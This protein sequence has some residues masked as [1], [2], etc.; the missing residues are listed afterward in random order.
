MKL[1]IFALVLVFHVSACGYA[2]AYK[3]PDELSVGIEQ[4][5]DLI[6]EYEKIKANWES[7]SAEAKQMN[8]WI[9]PYCTFLKELLL[10]MNPDPIEVVDRYSLTTRNRE[11]SI[12]RLKALVTELTSDDWL[13]VNSKWFWTVVPGIE[14]CTATQV[15]VDTER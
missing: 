1:F 4:L 10:D 5:R 3:K 11:D 15:L 12:K 9:T 8:Q 6:K 14:V 13:T 2:T 7:A